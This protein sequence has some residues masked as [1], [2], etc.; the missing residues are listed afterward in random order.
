MR[1]M[2]VAFC[3]KKPFLLK[4]LQHFF[5]MIWNY[6][7]RKTL[8]FDPNEWGWIVGEKAITPR[9]MTIAEGSKSR[10]KLIK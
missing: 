2:F 4:S 5:R 10:I 9:W 1:V 8:E 3:S 7:L 6:S